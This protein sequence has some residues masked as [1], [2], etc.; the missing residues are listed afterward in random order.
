[1][2]ALINL[3]GCSGGSGVSTPAHSEN[4]DSAATAQTSQDT[5]GSA[6]QDDSSAAESKVDVT[7]SA[8]SGEVTAEAT[9]EAQTVQPEE[10]NPDIPQRKD[11]ADSGSLCGTVYIGFV[12][13]DSDKETCRKAFLESGYE[14][15][16]LS[17]GDIPDEYIASSDG[18]MDLFL[19]IPGNGCTA[20]VYS[21]DFIEEND[22]AGQKGEV[23]LSSNNGAPFLLKC[24]R[25]DIMPDTLVEVTDSEGNTL[26]WSP[27]ISMKD[28]RVMVEAGEMTVYDFTEYSFEV[29]TD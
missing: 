7:E 10:W 28:G 6:P 14:S 15:T 18:G 2:L 5:T 22:F 17:V 16:F 29:I 23:I 4:T 20:T 9:V 3:A 1:M 21:W 24:N 19:V 12:E 8:P 26:S 11:I 27:A 13:P 25:S